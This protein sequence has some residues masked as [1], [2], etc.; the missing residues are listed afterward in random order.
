MGDSSSGGGGIVAVVLVVIVI[1]LAVLGFGAIFGVRLFT[2]SRSLV[3]H[4]TAVRLSAPTAAATP[5]LPPEPTPRKIDLSSAKPGANA[6]FKLSGRDVAIDV[7]AG[8]GY[9]VGTFSLRLDSGTSLG[10]FGRDG[11]IESAWVDDFNGD[12]AEDFLLVVRSAGSGSYVDLRLFTAI[13]NIYAMTTLPGLPKLLRDGYMGHDTVSIDKGAITR[14]FPLYDDSGKP[15]LDRNYT[16][17][18]AKGG[19]LPIKTG[20]DS[21]ADPSGGKRT[22]VYDF[23]ARTWVEQ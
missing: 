4:A 18:D 8:E 14:R 22:V 12:G 2:H 16:L 11:S 20:A 19:D 6:A 9:S 13:D 17:E 1:V 21:N 23:T 5:A 10:P 7:P 3:T 15:R